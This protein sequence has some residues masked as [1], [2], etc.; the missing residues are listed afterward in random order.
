MIILCNG[1]LVSPLGTR[2][3][4]VSDGVMGGV[5]QGQLQV[6]HYRGRD[7]L[8]LSGVV[9]TANNG[10][11]I[12][13]ALDLPAGLASSACRGVRL[14]V[15]GNDESYNLHWRTADLQRP[16]QAYRQSFTVTPDWQTLD[17]PF[18][19]LRAYRTQQIFRP[20]CLIRIGLVAIGRDF[21]AELYLAEA[22]LY[23]EKS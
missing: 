6:M 4:L 19:D 16:W 2:W 9:T 21:N 12:Q 8:C 13:M 10:G 22:L 7:S 5:S 14:T 23:R 11:F 3:R 17:L 15:A 18:N 1:S 20:E